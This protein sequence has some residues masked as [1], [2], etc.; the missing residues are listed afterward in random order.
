M[1][2]C[3]TPSIWKSWKEIYCAAPVPDVTCQIDVRPSGSHTAPQWREADQCASTHVTYTPNLE[4][5]ANLLN[6]GITAF[7]VYF[8]AWSECKGSVR[9]TRELRLGS[10]AENHSSFC[11]EGERG[12][13]PKADVATNPER[14]CV[15]VWIPVWVETDCCENYFIFQKVMNQHSFYQ[16][17]LPEWSNP[18]ESLNVFRELSE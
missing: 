10:P 9:K 14:S 3:N 11:S 7:H 13:H 6:L 2:L 15:S 8:C 4:A 16:A 5:W 18:T 17:N 1:S 12:I